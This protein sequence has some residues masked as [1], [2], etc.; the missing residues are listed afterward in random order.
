[1]KK[2]VDFVFRY[3]HKVREIESLMLLRL[4]LERRGYTVDFVGNY[5]Y[6]R[7]DFSQPRVFIAPA[8]YTDGQLQGDI[9]RYGMLK[10]IAN[11]QWEQLIGVKEEEYPHGFHNIVGLGQ[12]IITFCWGKRS[13]DR[14][15]NTGVD[16]NK[17]PVVG[18]INTDLLRQ[19]FNML[20]LTKQ[21]L[22]QKYQ[23][24]SQKKWYLFISSFAYCE[25]DQFQAKL[26]KEALGDDGFNEFARVSYESRDAILDWFEKKLVSTPH[27]IIIYRP[28]PDETE[29]CQRLKDMAEKYSNFRVIPSEAMKHWV[30]ACDKIYNWFSTGVVD[31]IVMGKPLRML[32]P[33]HI[34]EYL[35]YRLMIDAHSISNQNEFDDDFEDTTMKEVIDK[36]MFEPY[37]HLSSEPVYKSICDI[38]VEM[39]KTKRYDIKYTNAERIK[40]IRILAAKYIKRIIEITFLRVLPK[41]FYPQAYKKLLKDRE[42]RTQ[43]LKDGYKKNVASQEE[44]AYFSELYRPLIYGEEV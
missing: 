17:V 27:T 6:D 35:D 36:Q 10:K 38:L 1:M 43:M 3:E 16:K 15:V 29:R 11:L 9:L 21:Q 24:D 20:L 19:P 13:H 39:L 4:E 23:I 44:I 18:Q 26:A 33:V 32:R 40:W 41:R 14:F 12:H 28:H 30:N 34:P 5:E 31:V 25:M 7:R 2:K 37:Y 22:G 42:E 8:V